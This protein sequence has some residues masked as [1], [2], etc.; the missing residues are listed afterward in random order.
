MAWIQTIEPE[1]ADDELRAI[2]DR[3][4]SSRGKLS[5][6][7][8]VQSLAPTALAAH[9]DLYLAL[10]FGR[11]PLTRA[12]REAIAVVVSMANRC[13]YCVQHHRAALQAHWKDP[14]AVR[15]L[16]EDPQHGEL[17]RR[18]R[19][20]LEYA[21][22]ITRAIDEVQERDIEKLRGHGLTDEE[23]LHVNLIAAYFNYVNRI[24]IGLGL[25]PTAAE[26]D[27]YRYGT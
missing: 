4:I 14:A 7:M 20:I 2:Y 26:V 23:I 3:V 18:L 11:S 17:D 12:D 21:I 19:A 13:E 9:L 8:R 10:L 6:I 15:Q 1:A 16:V 24:A 5:D 25:S 27:G 22:K